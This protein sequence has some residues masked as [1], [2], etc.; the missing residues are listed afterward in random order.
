MLSRNKCG[1]ADGTERRLEG[2]DNNEED[3]SWLS[4]GLRREFE[5]FAIVAEI[6]V[7]IVTSN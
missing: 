4:R 7:M 2:G 3:G 6:L 1:N 5:E